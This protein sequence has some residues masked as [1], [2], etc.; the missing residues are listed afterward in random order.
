MLGTQESVYF[1]IP[2]IGVPL[3]ADQNFNI[4]NYVK[5]KVAVKVE[6]KNFKEKRIKLKFK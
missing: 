3:F 5:K 4:N 1:G 6:L 2:L